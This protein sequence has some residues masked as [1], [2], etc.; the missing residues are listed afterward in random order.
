M[1]LFKNT[2]LAT[3]FATLLCS[4]AVADSPFY[5]GASAGEADNTDS[6]CEGIVD[7]CDKKDTG[8][9]VFAGYEFTENIAFEL[10]YFDLG[11]TNFKLRDYPFQGQLVDLD[12]GETTY[13][14]WGFSVVP[15]IEVAHSLF[16]FGRVG[17]VNS[18]VETKTIVSP[19]AGGPFFPDT[20]DK[21]RSRDMSGRFGAG[22]QYDLTP[23]FA[24]RAE[25]EKLQ[26]LGD[27]ETGEV[28][29]DFLTAS[30][31]YKF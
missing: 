2:T 25:Y 6:A 22:I 24:V 16:I 8:F 12:N 10:D 27:D 28:D 9:K 31:V 23:E 1:D 21:R 4:A 7:K 17:F 26:N 5:I 19:A 30:I 18:T 11:E 29:T 20:P 3:T 13:D 14:G 15:K